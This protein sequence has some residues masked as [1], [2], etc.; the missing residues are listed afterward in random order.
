MIVDNE[1][2]VGGCILKFVAESATLCKP[3]RSIEGPTL[4]LRTQGGT[5]TVLNRHVLNSGVLAR[6]AEN[7]G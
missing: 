1:M 4:V 5:S 7:H 2:E 3:V 6:A